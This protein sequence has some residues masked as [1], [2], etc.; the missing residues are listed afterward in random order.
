MKSC[1]ARP[2]ANFCVKVSSI[3]ELGPQPKEMLEIE[4]RVILW[5]GKVLIPSWLDMIRASC[6]SSMVTEHRE[7]TE[8][9]S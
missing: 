4:T 1:G 2:E 6:S 5:A 9:G 8:S 7:A 3:I